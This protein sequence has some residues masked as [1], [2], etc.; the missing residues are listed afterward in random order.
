MNA[1]S[2]VNT[3]P[4]TALQI[5][6]LVVCAVALYTSYRQTRDILNPVVIVGATFFAPMFFVLFRLSGYQSQSWQYETYVACF[7]ALGAWAILPAILL[8][9]QGPSIK[10]ES[11]IFDASVVQSPA[12][13]Y[14]SRLAG[15]T[16]VCAFFGSNYIQSGMLVPAMHPEIAFQMHTDFAPG[17]RLFARAGCAASVLLYLAF[18]ASRKKIDIFLLLLVAL[19]P[20]T[21]LS[22]IDIA[23]TLVAIIILFWRLPLFAITK[24]RVFYILVF[25]VALAVG[26]SELGNLRQ[27][28]FG[29]YD[30]T[31][32]EMIK[33]R[34]DYAG[35]SDVLAVLYGYFPLSFEN[36]DA[37]VYQSSGKRTYFLFSLDWL[38]TGFLKLNWLPGLTAAQSEAFQFQPITSAANVPTALSPFYADLGPILIIIPL[39]VYMS[40]WVG[41][42]IK[43]A[44]NVMFLALFAL[45]SGAFA[46]SSFQALI[47]A[48]LI[49]Q[50][51]LGV[52][53]V[54]YLSAWWRKQKSNSHA[55]EF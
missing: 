22:R 29:V 6:I 36:F 46:L 35:P 23:I 28:R 8:A 21:K 7:A 51:L 31:Y 9:T 19:V 30:F 38:F 54:F 1:I 39:L 14:L 16:V 42:Y 4:D 48:P 24:I 49:I 47:A 11:Y 10:K 3:N 27:N 13:R 15:V 55:K 44:Q 5:T 20:L 37:F 52:F 33:W 32:S 50:Q 17:L 41:L 34:L 53:V 2:A 18:W 25:V 26:A 12:F 40:I 45:Y 43:A